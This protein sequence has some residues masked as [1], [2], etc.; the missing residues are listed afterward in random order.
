[1]KTIDTSSATQRELYTYLITAIAPRPIALASTID[2]DGNVNLSP[3]SYFN[4]FSANPPIVIFSP[5]R[6]GRENT[7]KDTYDNV[8]QVPEVA[9]N[10][11]NYPIVEQMSLTS[12]DY[13]KNVDEFVKSGLTPVPSDTIQPPYVGEAPVALECKVTQIIE[14]GDGPGAGN[15]VLAKVERIHINPQYLDN[16]GKLDTPKLDLVARMGG[17]W[18][19]RAI[20]EALFQIPKPLGAAGIG[21]DALP[22]S[23]RESTVLTGND[24]ARLGNLTALP[25]A[26]AIA[27]IEQE[28]DVQTIL[29]TQVRN[30][31]A[32]HQLAKT[33]IGN[34]NIERA[35]TLLM[36]EIK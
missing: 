9:I 35:L 32:I 30:R 17:S 6:R 13:P 20:P 27:T 4:M 16:E 26:E 14:L 31:R 10:I 29:G 23:V 5:A 3:F 36:V 33:Y 8:K 1:M 19:C 22:Q 25:S 28:A 12:A 21:V 11:V 34:G 7:T 18:Y 24:L 2:A 15:L